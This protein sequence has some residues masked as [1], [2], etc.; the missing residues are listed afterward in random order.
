MRPV[1]RRRWRPVD[2]WQA[3]SWSTTRSTRYRPMA[4]TFTASANED[5]SSTRIVTKTSRTAFQRKRFTIR[6]ASQSTSPGLEAL[7]RGLANRRATTLKSEAD[8][9]DLRDSGLAR[10]GEL[11]ALSPRDWRTSCALAGRLHL[12]PVAGTTE[13]LGLSSVIGQPSSSHRLPKIGPRRGAASACASVRECPPSDGGFVR[14][15]SGRG[16]RYLDQRLL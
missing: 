14:A 6:S 3:S 1:L 10:G 8:E 15:R 2:G 11:D 4:G 5:T 7:G 12:V 13:G 16:P 9:P